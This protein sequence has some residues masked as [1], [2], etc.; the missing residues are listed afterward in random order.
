MNRVYSTTSYKKF[1]LLPMNR[2]IISSHVDTMSQS[3]D[4]MGV[5]RPVVCCETN[6]IEGVKK[7]YVVDG[8]H[9]LQSLERKKMKVDYVKIE[10]DTPLEL[11]QKMGHLNST[12]KS[13][14]LNDYVNAYKMLIPD[15][16]TL[17]KMRNLYNLEYTAIAGIGNMSEAYE[18]RSVNANLKH[19]NFKITND[20]LAKH[21]EDVNKLFTFI[22]NMEWN[23]KRKLLRAFISMHGTHDM[24]SVMANMKK[25]KKVLQMMG[26]EE[27]SQEFVQKKIFGLKK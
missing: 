13:W 27:V 10:A 22:T 26:S 21:C 3:I 4:T 6:M 17:F 24:K 12:S 5:I 14:N 20:K 11:V 16:M 8:Q 2:E 1:S 18:S 19:G 25:H 15:Y 9:L 7:L 23:L